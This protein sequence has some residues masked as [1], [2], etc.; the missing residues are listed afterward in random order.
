MSSITGASKSASR[1]SRST[2]PK[3]AVTWSAGPHPPAALALD[4]AEDGDHPVGLGDG[5]V[6][7]DELRRRRGDG[8]RRR[9]ERNQV[10]GER[11]Q[12]VERPGGEHL[13]EP[14]VVLLVGQPA[15][16]V[17]GAEQRGDLVPV[18]V[19][20]AQRTAG[21]GPTPVGSSSRVGS[22]VVSGLDAVASWSCVR[23]GSP[24]GTFIG[25]QVV[26]ALTLG[27]RQACWRG[28]GTGF[29]VGSGGTPDRG[30]WHPGRFRL[31][32]CAAGRSVV[33]RR[34]GRSSMAELQLPKLIVRVRFPSSAPPTTS[35]PAQPARTH[36][37]VKPPSTS[38]STPVQKLAASLSR[39]TAGP[40]SSSTLRHPAERGVGLELADLVGDLGAGVHRRGG[41]AGADGVDPDAAV[42]PLHG[43]AARQVDDGGL[44]RVVVGLQQPAVD[45][46]AGHRGDV[47]DRA[48][49]ARQHRPRLGLAGQEDAGVVDV[50]HP[51]PLRQRHLL[52]G[53]GVGD[54]GAVD[55]EA[56]RPELGL[57]YADG[58]GQ[59]V[60]VGDVA[61]D[62]ERPPAGR[63]DLGDD[64][65]E[66]GP[67][68]VE[69]G[70]VG[71][72]GGEPER[73]AAADAAGRRR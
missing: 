26:T 60:G 73:D 29:R 51:L 25:V 1:R 30:G 16:G 55:G 49:T 21:T 42:G 11:D 33:G 38:R 31:D 65:V 10:R 39:N 15:L 40:T 28:L 20:G 8:G 53:G 4:P 41:V 2:P 35:A 67:G 57:A 46:R 47:D 45:D 63:L 56:E 54:A 3:T 7:D 14:L 72:A 5:A 52:G 18:G 23:P 12:V 27:P 48:A 13:L 32:S 37:Q 59:A 69:A 58:L 71:A 68:E 34:C 64:L 22:K 24:V 61:G 36:Q 66:P 19:G 50:D 43:Q 62:G 44:G 6:P 17:R 9:V 70:D